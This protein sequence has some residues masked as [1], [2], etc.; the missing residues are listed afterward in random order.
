M[1]QTIACDFCGQRAASLLIG[2]L[3]NGQQLATCWGDV[4][5]ACEQLVQI[6]AAAMPQPDVPAPDAP[7]TAQ[8]NSGAGDMPA[9]RPSEP[10]GETPASAGTD[11]QI[12]APQ[13]EPT[14]ADAG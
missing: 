10:E 4:P 3:D 11:G 8:E 13:A 12:E 14:A 5:T 1:A 6:A 2:N 7:V 9:P